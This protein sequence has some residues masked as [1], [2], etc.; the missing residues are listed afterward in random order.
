MKSPKLRVPALFHHKASGQAA[1]CVRD[2]N[3]K[4]RTVYLGKFGTVAA[5]R[6]YRQVLA[7]SLADKPV[8][9][10]RA[11]QAE[12]GASEWPSV[13]QLCAAYLLHAERYY[14]DERGEPTGEVYHAKI[15]FRLLLKLHRKAT[16]DRVRIADLMVVR[17]ALIDLRE[18]HKH[19]RKCPDGLS[20]RTINDRMARIKRLFRWGVEQGIVPGATWHELSAFRGLPKGRS[21]VRDN[22]PVEAVTW[23]QVEATLA[24][25][26][27]TF[28][29]L[30]RLQWWS[31]VRPGEALALTRRQL[32]TSGS[33][34]LF[35]LARH[36][37]SWRGRERVVA[38]GPKAQAVLR[39]RLRLE[40][41]APIFSGRNAWTEHRER[42]RQSR[43]TPPSKQMRERDER[44]S[45][46]AK[47]V[48]EW[49]SVDEYR[50]AIHRA[51]D[52]AGIPRWSPHR[53]RHAAGTRIAQEAGIEAARA[54]LGHADV[55][56]S[57]RYAHGADV[58]IAKGIAARM[59]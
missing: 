41:D 40:Q 52:D 49:I 58:E 34:W 19:G 23:A 39:S 14:R 16:T 43:K 21:G 10:V 35:R 26:V 38:L 6:R 51:C 33:T 54:A 20:R 11:S 17:Q 28:V 36:K 13:G 27:P 30:V 53:L 46:H 45:A 2:A 3:G 12:V 47:Q 44:G 59:G 9:G 7:E 56:T 15:A 1:V 18:T 32:E 57:R 29:D 50:R 8:K 22:A 48:D 24:H 31:G 37:G 5:Q 25:L 55:A 4:R 42:R